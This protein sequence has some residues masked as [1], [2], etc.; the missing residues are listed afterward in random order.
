M[1]CQTLHYNLTFFSAD[2]SK[3]ICGP[4]MQECHGVF[5]KLPSQ[6]TSQMSFI[7]SMFVA[8]W[9]S[10]GQNYAWEDSHKW[11][12]MHPAVESE[13]Y[14]VHTSLHM[15][16]VWLQKLQFLVFSYSVNYP[17]IC[18]CFLI[19]MVWVTWIMIF[20]LHKLF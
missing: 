10:L 13:Q 7:V 5:S 9:F 4:C 12:C 17:I 1:T 2:L 3:F 19:S 16:R 6:F 15:H 20:C 18:C 8:A 11:I 14:H